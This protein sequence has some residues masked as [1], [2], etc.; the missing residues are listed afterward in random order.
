M[1]AAL[2]YTPHTP[3]FTSN[4]CTACNGKTLLQLGLLLQV[5]GD[6]RIFLGFWLTTVNHDEL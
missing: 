2:L 5:Q 3:F 1:S 4:I 6:A